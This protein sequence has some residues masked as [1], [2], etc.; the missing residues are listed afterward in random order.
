MTLLNKLKNNRKTSAVIFVHNTACRFYNRFHIIQCYQCQSFGHKKGS[1]SCP[2]ISTN[3]NTCLYCSLN[4]PSKDCIYKRS[5]EKYNCANCKRFS[6]A[7]E[8]ENQINHTTTDQE[9][10]IFQK[11]IEL[12][13]KNTV[14][15][16]KKSKNDFAK[17]V[18][19]T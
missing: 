12:V 8:S 11:Q 15:I 5:P 14:G 17:H 6:C 16:T 3:N 2:L 4:H 1:A 19:V 7:E 13:L 10:P 18:F 9:C